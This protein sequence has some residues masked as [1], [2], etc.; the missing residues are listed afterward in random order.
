MCLFTKIYVGW[1]IV[2]QAP[3]LYQKMIFPEK[4]DERM[5]CLCSGIYAYFR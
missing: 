1:G 4:D 5:F 3:E 2:A